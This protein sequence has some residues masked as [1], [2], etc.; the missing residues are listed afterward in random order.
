MGG[1]DLERYR[2][3]VRG[4][5]DDKEARVV[6]RNLLVDQMLAGTLCFLPAR[7]SFVLQRGFIAL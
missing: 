1:T 2:S 5:W 6:V 4:F 3:L 7:R